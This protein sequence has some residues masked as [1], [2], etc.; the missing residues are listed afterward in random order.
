[1][2]KDTISKSVLIAAPVNKVAALIEDF[3]KITVWNPM[4]KHVEIKG[5]KQAIAGASV[6]WGGKIGLLPLSGSSVLAISKSGKE[7]HWENRSR[8]PNFRLDG[9]FL[10]EPSNG[11]TKLVGT[12]VYEL[13]FVISGLAS[14]IGIKRALVN[15]VEEAINNI[16][17]IV[18]SER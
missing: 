15:G 18:E 7:Y 2:S 6:E 14:I 3:N 4:L 9:K 13:P 8:T 1:M 16:K 11:G 12:V 5:D 10:L 17:N